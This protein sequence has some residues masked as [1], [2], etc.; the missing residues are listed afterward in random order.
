MLVTEEV[1]HKRVRLSPN[2]GAK[3]GPSERPESGPT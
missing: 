1:S 3:S 2:N